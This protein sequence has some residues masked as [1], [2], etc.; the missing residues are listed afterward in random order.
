MKRHLIVVAV[1]IAAAGCT[2]TVHEHRGPPPQQEE[3]VVHEDPAPPPQRRETVVQPEQTVDPAP[4]PRA[5]PVVVDAQPV[6]SND[7]NAEIAVAEQAPPAPQAEV[8]LIDRRP[9]T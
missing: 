9:S 5:Q 6:A 4:P 7:D 1:F 2:V 8:V 3:V